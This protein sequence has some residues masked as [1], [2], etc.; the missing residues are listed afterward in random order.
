ML[1]A[2]TCP[3]RAPGLPPSRPQ[4]PLLAASGTC[5][6][7]HFAAWVYSVQATSLTHSLL[8]VSATPLFLAG[9]TWLLR[10]PISAGELAGTGVGAVGAVLLATDA[11]RS[12]GQ[13]RRG[14]AAGRDRPAVCW[15]P[16]G[17]QAELAVQLG[18]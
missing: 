12:D 18:T 13:V 16:I 10:K 1:A 9:G 17:W 11:A 5:L 2:P 15:L 6:C 4:A 7:V 14:A 8:F 3:A